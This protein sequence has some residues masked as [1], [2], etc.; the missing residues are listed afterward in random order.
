MPEFK[1]PSE[2]SPSEHDP[3]YGQYIGLVTEENIFDALEDQLDELIST[4]AGCDADTANKWRKIST[5]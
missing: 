4:V 2:L 1:S 5:D 3:F